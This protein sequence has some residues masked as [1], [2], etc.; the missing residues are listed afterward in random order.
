MASCPGTVEAH[1]LTPANSV[2]QVDAVAAVSEGLVI[3]TIL[4]GVIV[5]ASR[6]MLELRQFGDDL[7]WCGVAEGNSQ[8]E[9][10]SDESDDLEGHVECTSSG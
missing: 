1:V 4:R 3:G 2:T 5:D 6:A 8:A 9:C 10:E 7:I